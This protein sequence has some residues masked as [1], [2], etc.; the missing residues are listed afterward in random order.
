MGGAGGGSI[1][2]PSSITNQI[3]NASDITPR[4]FLA[5]SS[6]GKKQINGFRGSSSRT[7]GSVTTATQLR[8]S[9]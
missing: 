7:F 2:I 6:Q 4:K 8:G 5:N 9:S 3:N 1:T